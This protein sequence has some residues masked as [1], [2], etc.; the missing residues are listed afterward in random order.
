LEIIL[1]LQ[2]YKSEVGERM[3]EIKEIKSVPV[4]PF[5]LIIRTIFALI[6]FI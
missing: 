3:G 1:R 6:T 5:A 4:V 2:G